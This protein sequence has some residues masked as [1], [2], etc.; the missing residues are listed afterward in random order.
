[1]IEMEC[2]YLKLISGRG[3]GLESDQGEESPRN[4]HFQSSIIQI[5]KVERHCVLKNDNT[6]GH[7]FRVFDSKKERSWSFGCVTR[8]L[9]QSFFQSD[10]IML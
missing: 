1:M 6:A 7:F 10:V 4:H 3:R 9:A 5:L 8:Y 2:H